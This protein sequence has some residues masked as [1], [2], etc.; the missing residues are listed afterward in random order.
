MGR[1][2]WLVIR[3]VRGDRDGAGI[4]VSVDPQQPDLKPRVAEGD[5]GKRLGGRVPLPLLEAEKEGPV[6]SS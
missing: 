1:R 2:A 4:D 6:S 3:V 5:T